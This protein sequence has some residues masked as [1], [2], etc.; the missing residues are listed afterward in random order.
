MEK[1]RYLI[2]SVMFAIA[3]LS[4]YGQEP[5][6]IAAGGTWS[7]ARGIIN[8]NMTQVYDSLASLRNS[9]DLNYSFI[10]SHADSLVEH[11]TKIQLRLLKADTATMLANYTRNGELNTALGNYVAEA[12][13]ADM[14]SPYALASELGD[15][16][17]STVFATRYYSTTTFAPIANPVFTGIQKVS[18]TDTLATMSYARQYGGTGTVTISDVQDEIADSLNV[19]RPLYVETADTA[20]ILANY[21]LDSETRAAI[22]DSL[23]ARIGGGVELSDVAVMLADSTGT[24]EGSYVTG[25]AFSVTTALKVNVADST[26]TSE[27]N[28]VTRKALIDSLA[29]NPAGLSSGAVATMIN[30]SIQARLDAAVD[31]VRLVDS[32][33]YANGYMSRYDGVIGLAAKINI[34]DSTGNAVGNYV[35]H[36]ALSD[37]L[38]AV[39]GVTISDVRD[40]IADSL[41][42]LRPLYVEVADSAT[43]LANYALISEV[44]AIVN[45]TADVVRGEMLT[46]SDLRKYD[47]DTTTLFVF[48]AGSGG[49][50]ADT[51][52]FTT[53]NIYGSFY[54]AG[55]DTLIITSLRAVM[56]AGTTPSGTD[57]LAIQVYWNDTINVTTGASVVVLNTSALGINSTTTGTVDA[58]FD[59]SAI[60]PN[61]WVFCKSPGVVTGRKPKALYVDLIGYKRNRSY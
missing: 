50:E 27:G 33:N 12:D 53:S 34:A 8:T 26:G 40:E 55:S 28:Y 51:A 41:N 57:T 17:D 38:S 20:T 11:N 6:Q 49:A 2:L 24:A 58:S 23:D 46:E 14:L 7:T 36:K 60:P 19:L 54:N 37:S 32:V 61:V 1:I 16:A 45:D 52:L 22:N 47:S 48:G 35:T 21:I 42:V 18:T 31:G 5:T 39:S 3:T 29:A 4:V 59:N 44:R 9:T 43:M 30:D 15:A 10:S 25:H 13:T 56:I